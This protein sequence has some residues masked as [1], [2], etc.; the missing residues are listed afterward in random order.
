MVYSGSVR[1]QVFPITIASQTAS[2]DCAKG[3]FFTVTL[4]SGSTRLEATNILPGETLSLR[5]T[6]ATSGSQLTGSLSVK[7]PNG[8]T[9]QPTPVSGTTDIVTF[10]TFDSSSIYAVGANYFL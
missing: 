4:P 8:F 10:L 2:M 6:N 3:N 7:F 1:G 5:I 9:Y